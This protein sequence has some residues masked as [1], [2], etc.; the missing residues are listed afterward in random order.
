MSDVEEFC[1]YVIIDFYG[2]QIT[3]TSRF[4]TAEQIKKL[5]TAVVDQDWQINFD[6]SDSSIKTAEGFLNRG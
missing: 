2:K 6:Y 4:I 1:R 3:I 5:I